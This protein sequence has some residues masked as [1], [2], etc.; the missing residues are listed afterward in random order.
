MSAAAG[1][2][3]T[4]P[5]VHEG[6]DS[7]AAPVGGLSV[8]QSQVF[9]GCWVARCTMCREGWVSLARPTELQARNAGLAHMARAH[10][11]QW[12]GMIAA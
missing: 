9:I 7:N 11:G 12:S 5:V 10:A 1:I 2:G 4:L 3:S 6:C 8:Y